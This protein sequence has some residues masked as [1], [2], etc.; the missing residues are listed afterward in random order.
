MSSALSLDSKSIKVQRKALKSVSW[1][2]L[3][4]K[5][6]YT[7]FPTWNPESNKC[8]NKFQAASKCKSFFEF[9]LILPL[10]SPL[11]S[12]KKNQS[13]KAPKFYCHI[14]LFLANKI[15]IPGFLPVSISEISCDVPEIPHGYVRSSKKSYKENEIMQFFC[16]EGYKYGNRADALCTESGW[17]PPPYCI[18][19][20]CL[21]WFCTWIWFGS[22]FRD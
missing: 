13:K 22:N 17:N 4:L 6:C 18:G 2:N 20:S 9:R 10:H 19:Q 14:N 12:Q 15:K 11:P 3:Q 8:S 7:T 21:K 5:L 1:I 16:K